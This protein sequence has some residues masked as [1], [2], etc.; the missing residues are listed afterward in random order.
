ML[1]ETFVEKPCLFA[2]LAHDE[3]QVSDMQ[4]TI[5]KSNTI[6]N[7]FPMQTQV[8]SPYNKAYCRIQHGYLMS[9]PK[10]HTI[11]S[12]TSVPENLCFTLKSQQQV[13][14]ILFSKKTYPWGFIQN[15]PCPNHHV[16]IYIQCLNPWVT[17]N[18]NIKSKTTEMFV[19]QTRFTQNVFIESALPDKSI[20]EQ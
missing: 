9:V 11:L 5:N 6:C 12:R 10:K 13:L 3:Q 1:T 4:R 18:K 14:F 8:P 19:G 15:S 17:L 7:N 20:I 16:Y 2:F